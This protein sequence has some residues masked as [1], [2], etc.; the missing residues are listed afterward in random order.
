[1]KLAIAPVNVPCPILHI[2]T[3]M[4]IQKDQLLSDESH[5]AEFTCAICLGVPQPNEACV[6]TKTCQHV[7]CKSCLERWKAQTD[8]CPTC[9]EDVADVELKIASPL[10][11]RVLGKIKVKCPVCTW[12]GDLSDLDFHLVNS[13]NHREKSTATGLKELGNEKFQAGRFAEALKL[14][15]KALENCERDPVGSDTEENKSTKASLYANRAAALLKLNQPKSAAESC[16]KA[17]RFGAADAKVFVRWYTAL[18]NDGQFKEACRVLGQ[19]APL[20]IRSALFTH[21]RRAEAALKAWEETTRAMLR[22]D[23]ESAKVSIVPLLSDSAT[24]RY[25]RVMSTAAIV[26]AQVGSVDTALRLSLDSCRSVPEDEL[27]W[28]ARAT[29]LLS[30][31]QFQDA[32]RAAKQALRLSPDDE[33]AKSTLRNVKAV[34]S[35]VTAA[36][37]AVNKHEWEKARELLADLISGN[38][39]PKASPLRVDLLAERADASFRYGKDLALGSTEQVALYEDALHD[40]SNA[41]YQKDDCQRAW[42]TRLYALR[43]LNRHEEAV[44]DARELLNRW[45]SNDVQIR[46]AAERA[47]FELRKSKRPELYGVLGVPSVASEMEIKQAYKKAALITHPDKLPA[48]ATESQRKVAEDAFKVLGTALDVLGNSEKRE[49][50]D[51]GFDE[52]GI[53]EQLERRKHHR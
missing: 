30:N 16:E 15:D 46:N 51:K 32:Q 2:H 24:N 13:E 31:G 53:Q 37:E 34:E 3:T 45:G 28:I 39:L 29:A 33:F 9:R 38:T 48:G 42:L 52:R 44:V 6:A 11:Y 18:C 10:A 21:L 27:A 49:L 22:G 7:F 19:V 35:L 20:N 5:T 12:T 23:F 17:V 41:I 1:M 4:T 40:A 50:W 36:R 8:K 14:Y 43:E 47:E 26:E 25:H